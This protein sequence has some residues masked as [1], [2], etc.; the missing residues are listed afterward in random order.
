MTN[1]D[2]RSYFNTRAPLE[3]MTPGQAKPVCEKV[4]DALR[5]ARGRRDGRSPTRRTY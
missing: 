5:E 2:P 3:Y 4:F 1:I